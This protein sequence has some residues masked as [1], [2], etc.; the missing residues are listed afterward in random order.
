MKTE[1]KATV[2]PFSEKTIEARSSETKGKLTGLATITNS[3]ASAVNAKETT[4]EALEPAD[5]AKTSDLTEPTVAITT[6]K[7]DSALITA[8][9][10]ARLYRGFHRLHRGSSRLINAIASEWDIND[11]ED[12]DEEL[13]DDSDDDD[14][15]EKY[16]SDDDMDVDVHQEGASNVIGQTESKANSNSIVTNIATLR[17]PGAQADTIEKP[18]KDKVDKEP[19]SEKTTIISEKEVSGID[20]EEGSLEKPVDAATEGRDLKRRYTDWS[21]YVVWAMIILFPLLFTGTWLILVPPPTLT[22]ISYRH[23]YCL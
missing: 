8:A 10:G 13:S 14:D 21:R 23:P 22:R 15:E 1:T 7:A 5:S 19:E 17:T 3:Q 9:K 20:T 18:A 4:S 16:D 12:D 11:I 6:S 2:I